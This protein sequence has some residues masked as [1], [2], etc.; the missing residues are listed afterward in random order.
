MGFKKHF[1]LISQIM[2]IFIV[3]IFCCS[4]DKKELKIKNSNLKL[5]YKQ[6]ATKWTEALPVGNGRLGAM[7]FGKVYQERIQLNEESLWAGSKINNNNPKALQSL[8]KIRKLLFAEKNKQA[9][10][11]I[12]KTLLGTPPRIRSSQTLGDIF[13]EFDST[14]NYSNYKRELCLETG[15]CSISYHVGSNEVTQEIFCSA[16]DNILVVK[17]AGKDGATIN[18]T[19]SLLR[20]KDAEI[21]SDGKNRLLMKG[22]IIDE[23]DS[24]SGAAGAHIKFAAILQAVTEKGITTVDNNKLIVKNANSLQLIFTAASDYNIEKLD[25][26]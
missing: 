22:Q 9:Y 2:L 11:L 25:F 14:E 8:P 23:A 5:W 7:V 17:L 24:L 21:S 26:D 19:I 3:V 1:F 16:P 12:N 10:D 13:F 4:C 20:E 18:T 15:I 6:P